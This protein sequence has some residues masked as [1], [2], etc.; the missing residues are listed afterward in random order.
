MDFFDWSTAK[1]AAEFGDIQLIWVEADH[2]A[3]QKAYPQAG[4]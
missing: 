2:E 4:Q 3:I 1:I